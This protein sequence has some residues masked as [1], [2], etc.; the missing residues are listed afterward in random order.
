M[1]YE[2][3]WTL[4]AIESYDQNIAYLQKDWTDREIAH[5]V[6]TVDEKLKLI[7]DFPDLFI[8]TNKRKHIRRALI[9]KQITLFYR[10]SK[11]LKQIELLLFWDSRSN[12]S[13]L[14]L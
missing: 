11:K 1:A 4:R 9:N 6:N 8:E 12:P 7:A 2:I 13:I 14:Q 10:K 5:F 3:K